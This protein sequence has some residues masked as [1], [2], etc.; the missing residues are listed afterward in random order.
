MVE[1]GTTVLDVGAGAGRLAL[2]LALRCRHV[3]VVEPS[4]SMLEQLR[5][6][7]K[8]AEVH[9][10]TLVQAI[11]EEAIAPPADLVVCAHVVY[12][13]TEI[14]AFIGK[15]ASHAA[16]RVAIF[17]FMESPPSRVAPFWKP[18]YGEERLNMPAL[19]ELLQVL[20]E[21]DIY[22]DVR[23]LPP[24][25]PTTYESREEIVRQARSFLWITPGTEA[26]RRLEAVA[27][28]LISRTPEGYAIR[29][30]PP[31]RNALVTWQ[32]NP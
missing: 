9:N 13:V 8:E 2:P 15:L 21:M 16:R 1:P 4:E 14:D 31:R 17:V 10:I 12:G 30:V 27:Q 28:E 11:W 5:E 3:T 20:W 19:P 26:E 6:V 29:G 7:A 23:M 32:T 25:A 24:N 18:V 22:P